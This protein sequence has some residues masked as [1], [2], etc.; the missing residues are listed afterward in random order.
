MSLGSATPWCGHCEWNL[1][2]YDEASTDPEFGWVWVDRRLRGIAYRL[3]RRQYAE[4]AAAAGGRSRYGA[5]RIV[6]V[7]ASVLLLGAFAALVAASCWLLWRY[8]LLSLYT[9]L[10]ALGLATAVLMRP[11]LGRLHPLA[12]VVDADRAPELHRLIR[13]VAD[14]VG[15]PPPHVVAVDESFSAYT[16]AV[17]PR[18]RRVLCLGLPLWAALAPQERVALLG[19]ELGH[20]ANGDIR[21]GLLTQPAFTMLGH[22]A[23]ILSPVSTHN[24]GGGLIGLL[25]DLVSRVVLWTLSRLVLAGHLLLLWVG[26]RDGQRAEYRAD[27]LA[28]VAAGSTAAVGLM[29]TLVGMDVVQMMVCREARA[30]LGPADWRAVV[31]NTRVESAAQLPLR[32]QLSIR[33]DVSLFASHPPSGLRARLVE[34]RPHRDPRIVL[35]EDRAA[36]IDAEL[37]AEFAAV[38]RELAVVG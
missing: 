35:T 38:R 26:L 20:F 11:R 36:R 23:Q 22:A 3:S 9:V 37:A 1:D 16:S 34:A 7:V 18:R 21:R 19:H 10:A 27:E 15:V 28:S 6:L 2:R 33:R 24:P 5:A 13:E 17:G 8:P 4:L 31:A 12:R 25:T 29:D 14:V 30:G 32:R